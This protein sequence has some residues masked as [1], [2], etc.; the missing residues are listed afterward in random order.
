MEDVTRSIRLRFY[1]TGPALGLL[2]AL[3]GPR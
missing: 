3:E 1:A 2:D